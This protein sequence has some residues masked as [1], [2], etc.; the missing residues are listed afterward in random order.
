MPFCQVIKGD[1][2]PCRNYARKGLTCCY[3]HRKLENTEPV[4]VET[5]SPCDPKYSPTEPEQPPVVPEPEKIETFHITPWDDDELWTDIID[6][7]YMGAEEFVSGLKWV[8]CCDLPCYK[9]AAKFVFHKSLK[10]RH[11]NHIMRMSKKTDLF[12]MSSD[13]EGRLEIYLT[14]VKV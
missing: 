4:A 6:A 11:F 9:G 3:A 5:P 7:S 1:D 10:N 2:K 8:A 14:S 12:T 13:P